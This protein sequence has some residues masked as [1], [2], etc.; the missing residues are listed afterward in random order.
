MPDGKK[1]FHYRRRMQ[2]QTERDAEGLAAKR[3]RESSSHESAVPDPFDAEEITGRLAGDELAE[4]R[5]QRPSNDRI[6]RLE[7]KHDALADEVIGVRGG[8]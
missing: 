5:A 6:G 8:R 7:E 2:S 1:P 3:E 4:A